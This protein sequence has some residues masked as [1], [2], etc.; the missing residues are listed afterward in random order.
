M[1]LLQNSVLPICSEALGTLHKMHHEAS[2]CNVLVDLSEMLKRLH[3]LVKFAT[4]FP[5]NA[6]APVSSSVPPKLGSPSLALQN[7]AA[8]STCGIQVDEKF[9]EESEC[10]IL[11]LWFVMFGF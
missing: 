3:E 10:K 1:L 7:V 4:R 6:S 11:S 9:E 2:G 8:A 5:P